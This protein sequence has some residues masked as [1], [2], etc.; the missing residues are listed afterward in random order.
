VSDLVLE[1]HDLVK[2][3]PAGGR[4]GRR[5]V[6]HAL[7]GVSVGLRRGEMLGL[8]GE[9]GSGKST[10]GR[11]LLR[12]EEPSA[13]RVLV[14]G[15]DLADLRPREL[16][17][18]RRTMQMVFQ[19]PYGSLNPRMRVDQLVSEAWDVHPETAPESRRQ[20]VSELLELV[21][22]RDS[23]RHKHIHQ[24]SGGQRQRIAIA[25][26]LA[27][28]P[29]ILVCDEPVSALDVSIQAQIVNLLRDIQAEMDLSCVFISHDLAV[30]RHIADR[31][32]VLYLGRIA[33]EGPTRELFER[34]RHPYTAA[35]LSAAPVPDPT[36]ERTRRRIRL[37]K[38]I[39]N[40]IEPPSGCRFHARCWRAT[41]ECATTVPVLSPDDGRS[42]FACHHPVDGGLAEIERRAAETE[43]ALP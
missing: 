36:V 22:L 11:L 32:A 6:V 31:V 7:D 9:S 43:E 4:L 1:A 38:V 19:D 24:F 2:H 18:F 15:T 35:L 25:R 16:R 39:P 12:L 41:E 23:D 3:Y 21:G 40:P 8:V 14:E 10:L 20:R 30:V 37:P 34:P 13:G 17:R 28:R 29:S 5:R 33:E 26:A 42:R 27:P